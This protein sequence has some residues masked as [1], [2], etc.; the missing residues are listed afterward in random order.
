MAPRGGPPGPARASDGFARPGHRAR[1]A[2]QPELTVTQNHGC[3]AYGR[4]TAFR[5]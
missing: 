5:P 2:P 1:A 4:K 3:A